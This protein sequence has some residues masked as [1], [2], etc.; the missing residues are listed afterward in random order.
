MCGYVAC[1][2]DCCGVVRCASQLGAYA[3][4]RLLP[5]HVAAST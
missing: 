5:K 3:Y 2:P 4:G 1:V